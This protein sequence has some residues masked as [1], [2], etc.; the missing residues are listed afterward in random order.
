MPAYDT[1]KTRSAPM[2][3][4]EN[5]KKQAK[6]YVR[7]HREGRHTVAAMIRG[8]LPGFS[9]M[10]DRE[11]LDRSFKLADAQLLVARRSGFETWQALKQGHE[12]MTTTPSY[13]SQPILLNVE[14]SLFVT[15]FQRAL[16]FFTGKLGFKVAFTYGDPAFYG[17]VVRDAAPLNL[18]HV[19]RPVLDRS[20]GPDLLSV[21][22]WVSNA[23]QLFME[24]QGRDIPFH[25]TLR[26]EP[27]HG[28]GQGGFIVSDP[29]GNLISFGGRTD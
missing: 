22:I 5:L 29:D 13:P 23:K 9:A 15:D 14:P 6:L 28:Q 24:F 12:P 25:Q 16:D 1:F 18:R 2:P 17:Q 19:D 8:V 11:I 26:R 10:T 7:W 27:W 20:G 21:S 4:L 3:N